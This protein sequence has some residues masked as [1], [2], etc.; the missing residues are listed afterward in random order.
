MV[1]GLCKLFLNFGCKIKTNNLETATKAIYSRTQ[2]V[3]TVCN[4]TST[5]DGTQN[6]VI[7]I[8]RSSLFCIILENKY[9]L[10]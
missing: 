10:S 7:I 8:Q 2:P 9:S 4:H 5:M 3:I 6:T 1:S